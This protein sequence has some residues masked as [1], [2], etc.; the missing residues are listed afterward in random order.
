MAVR[1]GSTA[2][3]APA[4][5]K[6]LVAKAVKAPVRRN[7]TSGPEVDRMLRDA[8][9]RGEVITANINALLHRLG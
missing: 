3:R 6:K 4:R 5:A 2:E 9:A 1:S 7:G 8:K